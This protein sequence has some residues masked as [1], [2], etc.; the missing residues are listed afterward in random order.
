MFPVGL[1][2]C[3]FKSLFFI[4]NNLKSRFNLP[5]YC[6][7]SHVFG[8]LCRDFWLFSMLYSTGAVIIM[9]NALLMTCDYLQ[10]DLKGNNPLKTVF[11]LRVTFVSSLHEAAELSG[12]AVIRSAGGKLANLHVSTC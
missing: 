10:H 12:K 4:A 3:L 7:A 1:K 5:F 8:R 11:T 6:T 9:S 2:R